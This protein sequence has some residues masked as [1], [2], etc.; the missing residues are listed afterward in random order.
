MVGR[1]RTPIQF[2]IVEHYP[3]LKRIAGSCMPSGFYSQQSDLA[4]QRFS[5]VAIETRYARFSNRYNRFLMGPAFF[6]SAHYIETPAMATAT[7]LHVVICAQLRLRQSFSAAALPPVKCNS[8]RS[9][10]V[11]CA[12]AHVEAFSDKRGV[13][14]ATA[15][16]RWYPH[17][18]SFFALVPHAPDF[19]TGCR[20]SNFAILR[21]LSG[22]RQHP[23]FGHFDA[24]WRFWPLF[25]APQPTPIVSP[26]PLRTCPMACKILQ[27][28]TLGSPGIRKHSSID[29]VRRG[30]TA[31]QQG[32]H[33]LLRLA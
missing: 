33:A 12:P 22:D 6:S 23:L 17:K 20:L 30:E 18:C 25:V 1:L 32:D 8:R 15:A 9:A 16:G 4:V 10:H 13:Q 7:S 27:I 5:A 2:S 24:H 31:P 29:I 14:S 3:S 11:L 21:G 19:S 28:H 26:V